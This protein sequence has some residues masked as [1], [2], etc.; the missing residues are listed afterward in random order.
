MTDDVAPAPSIRSLVLLAV[1]AIVIGVVSALLLWSLEQLADLLEQVLWHG[2]P[3]AVGIA[4]DSPWLTIGVLTA[5]GLAVGLVVQFVPGHA[6]PD[7]ATTELDTPPP[8]LREVPSIALAVLISLAGGVS[9]GPENPIIAIN[10]AIAVALC[11]RFVKVVPTKIA[12]LL[13]SAATIGALFG[14]PVAAALVL[15]GTVAAVR[16]GGSLWDKLFLPVAAA[17]AGALTMHLLGAPPL[18]FDVPAYGGPSPADFAT[19][20]LVAAVSAGLGI[21]AAFVF[22]YIHRGFHALRHPVLF[23]TLGGLVL[24]IL[25]VIGG[26]ITLFK[27]LEQ[28]GELIANP[29]DYSTGQL[30]LFTIVKIVALLVAASAGFRG[31]RIFPAVFVGV[32]LGLFFQSIIPGMPI[33]LA[34]ACGAMGIVLQATKDGWMAIFVAVAMTGDI[35]LLPLLC[36]IV[37]PVWLLVTKAPELA[38]K[39]PAISDS[40][41][42]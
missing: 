41:S 9:L 7:S 24:G 3:D 20:L 1:P 38:V 30:A 29:G 22:P 18:A 42:P 32:A 33:G 40:S 26:Q 11:A 17:G 12:V 19:G 5:T 10:G 14:T 36:V 21:L 16:G 37:L 15:T 23:T 35:T 25:G 6:G 2:L 13:A 28:T 31:G 39:P 34:I 27:G 4:P 8:R